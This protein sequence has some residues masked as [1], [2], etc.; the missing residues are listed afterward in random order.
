[1]QFTGVILYVENMRRQTEFYRDV[2]GAVPVETQPFDPKRF[3]M[4]GEEQQ[5]TLALHRG[6]KPNGG[7]AKLTFYVDDILA[8]AER[9]KAAGVKLGALDPPD[10]NGGGNF[11]LKDPEGNR[12]M[13][14]GKFS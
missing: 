2:L 10:A 9:L 7:R 6:T 5:S 14:L 11:N 4:F 1:M 8:T 12:I 13:V 3:F